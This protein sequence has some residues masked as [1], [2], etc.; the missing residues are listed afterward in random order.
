MTRATT[1]AAA[2]VM[3]A[4]LGGRADAVPN[5][6]SFSAVISD[7]DGPIDGDVALEFKVFDSASGGTEMWA[8]IHSSAPASD[9]LVF[10]ELGSVDPVNNG[11][12]ATVFTGGQMWLELT[13]NGAVQ[14][15]RAKIG[16]VPY[17][18]V[19]GSAEQI[20]DMTAADVQRRVSG[21]CAMGSA[22]R[23]I[24]ADGT[25]TCETG[26]AS[27]V[28][29]V[30]AGA[31]L[32]GGGSGSVSLD[33]DSTY[34]QRR[35]GASCS[36]GSSIR[37]ISEDG[38]VTC[39]NVGDITDVNAGTGLTG[40]G[41]LGAVTLNADTTYLQRRVASTCTA[42]SAIRDIA[43]DG[44]VTCE[45]LVRPTAA[46]DT[47][48]STTYFTTS[49]LA[50]TGSEVTINAPTSGT[51]IVSATTW[52]KV[53]HTTGTDD[54]LYVTIGTTATDCAS[55]YYRSYYEAPS[56]YPTVTSMEVALSPRRTFSVAA[57]SHTYY[58]TG[59]SES[60]DA[61]SDRFWYAQMDAIFIPD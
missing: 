38:S 17:A 54:R 55:T 5:T 25:V 47:S 13:I 50:Y 16:S 42:G 61:T 40:G 11:L 52:V 2:L 37:A 23:E 46:T 24:G 29:D 56:A 7:A 41:S 30:T 58:L 28:T 1:W 34:V 26:G 4:A 45:T 14:S 18:T 12:D 3:L 51:V 22:I 49:C 31:G 9:G 57:G 48:G 8:E 60:G 33:V 15:P 36:V 19:A 39:E 32:T 21:N 20:G 10:V 43:A 44:S 6:L 27:G 59:R 53:D 35:V